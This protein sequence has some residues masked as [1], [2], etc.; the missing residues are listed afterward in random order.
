MTRATRLYIRMIQRPLL[1]AV[2]IVAVLFATT[3]A[4][5]TPHYNT[6]DDIG[7][8]LMAAGVGISD[9]PDE[10]L[11]FSHVLIGRMLTA[12]YRWRPNLVWYAWY[13]IGVQFAAHTGLVYSLLR[14]RT[15]PRRMAGYL[16]YFAT[17]GVYFLTTL[18]FT[19]TAFLAAQTGLALLISPARTR[20][21]Q[22]MATVGHLSSLALLVFAGLIRVHS[23][24]LALV[25]GL[26]LLAYEWIRRREAT[27]RGLLMA[28]VGTALAVSTL[29]SEYDRQVYASD[30][31]WRDVLEWTSLVS[32]FVNYSAVSYTPAT[33]PVF[34]RLN[35]SV[36]DLKMLQRWFWMDD[37]VYT[38]GALTTLV[39]EAG[40]SRAGTSVK[41][42]DAVVYV[43]T[44]IFTSFE[45][46]FVIGLWLCNLL[47]RDLT[48]CGRG[49]LLSNCLW[50]LLLWC[51]LA[52]VLM[53]CPNR[54]TVPLMTFPLV[55]ALLL[56]ANKLVVSHRRRWTWGISV[57]A[58]LAAGWIDAQY[59]HLGVTHVAKCRNLEYDLAQLRNAGH[60]QLFC[61]NTAFPWE[62]FLPLQ[63]LDSLRGFDMVPLTTAQSAP[64]G[65]AMLQRLH[66]TTLRSALEGGR[67]LLFVAWPEDM[68]LLETFLREH[69]Q[70][71]AEW[72]SV[73][74]GNSFT[75]YSLRASRS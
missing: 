68:A 20:H 49:V 28:T 15:S 24:Y 19:T 10:H 26:P 33:K 8:C 41:L 53:K 62:N 64:N 50:C 14:L 52:V 1:S 59:Y 9:A 18:Q 55:A 61:W 46:V 35:W 6:N 2:L 72:T 36:N 73:G 25:V 30:P 51:A 47:R 44:R 17:V 45:F 4:F 57:I 38:K 3:L 31:A 70:L 16:L 11:I 56:P 34:D 66:V 13:L 65:K 7:M 40:S 75:V 39:Q 5:I 22:G 32:P 63:P 71:N 74:A 23:L 29:L 42:T 54:V 67:Q 12:L 43:G 48:R 60:T 69:Y 27:S 37:E 21:C 58:L